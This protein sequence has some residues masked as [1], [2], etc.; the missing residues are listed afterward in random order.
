MQGTAA[1]KLAPF[2]NLK[3]LGGFAGE[4]RGEILKVERI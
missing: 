4:N 1:E 2:E 3:A